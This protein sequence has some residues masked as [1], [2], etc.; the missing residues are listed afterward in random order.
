MFQHNHHKIASCFCCL[1]LISGKWR[2]KSRSCDLITTTKGSR[3]R[4]RSNSLCKWL[5]PCVVFMCLFF[6][7]CLHVWWIHIIGFLKQYS[8]NN[9]HRNT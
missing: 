2:F 9:L 1:F 4:I 7:Q 3:H 6:I 5:N 8:H